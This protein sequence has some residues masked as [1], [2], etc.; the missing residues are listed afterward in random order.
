MVVF[1]WVKWNEGK[2][3]LEKKAYKDQDIITLCKLLTTI[4]RADRFCE[5]FLFSAFKDGGILAILTEIK[6]KI[7]PEYY[8]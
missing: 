3:I 1:D 2:E 5:G 6:R 8:T 7:E 4:A